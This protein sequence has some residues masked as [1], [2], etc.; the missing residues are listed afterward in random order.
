MEKTFVTREEFINIRDKELK[1]AEKENEE[2]KEQLEQAN[3]K[4]D[5]IRDPLFQELL[6]D[7]LGFMEKSYLNFD[8]PTYLKS[9]LKKKMELLK[10][11]LD[12]GEKE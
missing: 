6:R 3:K 7:T 11:I 4:I 1:E 8:K 12:K 9:Q 5:Y 2:L 10:S